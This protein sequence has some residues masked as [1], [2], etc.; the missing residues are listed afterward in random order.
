M[1]VAN[2]PD[3][4]YVY[5]LRELDFY[6]EVFDKMFRVRQTLFHVNLVGRFL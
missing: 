5:A 1:K 6:S 2:F 4:I 3:K